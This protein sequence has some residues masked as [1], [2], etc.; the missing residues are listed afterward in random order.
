[1]RIAWKLEFPSFLREHLKVRYPRLQS[2]V[3]VRHVIGRAAL[4][5]TSRPYSPRLPPK[6]GLNGDFHPS[7]KPQDF[8]DNLFRIKN[9]QKHQSRCAG[10]IEQPPRRIG[11]RELCRI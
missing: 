11:I 3:A 7:R 8:F 10:R 6:A 5:T 4:L 1:M 2:F 9:D